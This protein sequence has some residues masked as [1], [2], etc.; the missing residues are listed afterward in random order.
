MLLEPLLR[1]GYRGNRLILPDKNQKPP[2]RGHPAAAFGSLFPVPAR[3]S[4]QRPA[5]VLAGR[6]GEG[7]RACRGKEAT[8]SI[9][10]GFEVLMVCLCSAKPGLSPKFCPAPAGPHNGP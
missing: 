10:F 9:V 2:A 5:L 3:S 7:R 1:L 8:V 6:G 4:V